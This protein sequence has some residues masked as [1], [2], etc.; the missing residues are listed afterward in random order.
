MPPLTLLSIPMDMLS[1]IL[2]A[3]AVAD[4][5]A[6]AATNTGLQFAT[7]KRRTKIAILKIYEINLN[8]KYVTL[9]GRG[10]NNDKFA[11]LSEAFSMA[12]MAQVQVS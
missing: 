11:A 5:P 9:C 10:I 6:L 7:S 1:I 3:C 4:L 12:A 8:A 2:D